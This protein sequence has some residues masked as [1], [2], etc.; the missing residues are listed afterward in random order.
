ML[1][2]AM[3]A[4]TGFGSLAAPASAQCVL[5]CVFPKPTPTPAPTA[6]PAPAPTASPTPAPTA[7]PMPAPT[8]APA[9]VAFGF[10]DTAGHHHD[11]PEAVFQ[12]L[13]LDTGATLHRWVA[14][15]GNY[16]P[17]QGELHPGYLEHLRST[18]ERSLDNGVRPVIQAFGAPRW[19]LDPWA[20]TPG[21]G[22][23]CKDAGALCLAPPNVRD[24]SVRLG[25]KDWIKTLARTFPQAAAI[26]VWNEPN[27][28]WAWVIKQDP[29]LY[30]QMVSSAKL[31]LAE[32]GSRIPV[33]TG[34]L[35]IVSRSDDHYTSLEGMLSAIYSYGGKS[36]F[37]AISYHA[38]P[39]AHHADKTTLLQKTI[40]RVRQVKREQGD[41]GRPLWI[42]ETGAATGTSPY[43]Y[44]GLGFDEATQASTLRDVVTW[45]RATQAA[46]GDL[47]VMLVNSLV[48][49]VARADLETS[50]PDGGDEFGI[51]AWSYGADGSVETLRKPAYDVVRCAFRSAC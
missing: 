45:A 24:R 6:S 20:R 3:A 25:W 17:R 15:W 19:T 36:S 22:V 49:S 31:A 23:P 35:S 39:C 13:L 1:M 27:L 21:G 37:D 46:A 7:S 29:Q 14:S 30:A 2:A 5:A 51:V 40:D 33:L 43:A 50:N 32:V 42:T 12:D 44:C 47:R 28:Q 18:Y 34:G 4:L 9:P 10:N 38:Y 8:S 11:F 41:L 48:N 26:E 16:E